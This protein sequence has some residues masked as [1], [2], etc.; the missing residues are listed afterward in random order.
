MSEYRFGQLGHRTDTDLEQRPRCRACR[1]ELKRPVDR[2]KTKDGWWTNCQSCR[3]KHTA[4][5]RQKIHDDL[6]KHH[7]STISI[8]RKFSDTIDMDNAQDFG[9][10]SDD[11]PAKSAVIYKFEEITEAQW[12][13][14]RK[15]L[16]CVNCDEDDGNFRITPCGHVIC[17]DCFEQAR[18]L[19]K[20]GYLKYGICGKCNAVFDDGV[21][22]N[23]KVE[24]L[25]SKKTKQRDQFHNT[26]ISPQMIDCAVCGDKFL[27]IDLADLS[28]CTHNPD[29]CKA[30]L[31]QWLEAQLE[32][33]TWEQMQCPSD[34]CGQ[35]LTHSDV[36]KYA[37][38]ELFTRY[39]EL[40]MRAFL[41]ADP[42]FRYCLAEG[43]NSGQIHDAE[44]ENNI[45]RCNACGFR[46]CTVHDVPFHTGKTCAQ[47]DERQRKK[48][49]KK[50]KRDQERAEQ[51]EMS[52]VEIKAST[53][54]CPGCEVPIHK[55][56]ACDHI[57]CTRC[58]F[59]F[60]YICRAPY[61]GQNGIFTAGNKVHTAEC[62]Y[63][64]QNLP[65][66]EDPDGPEVVIEHTDVQDGNPEDSDSDLEEVV[67]VHSYLEEAN[68]DDSDIENSDPEEA[69][70]MNSDGEGVLATADADLE[71]AR[72]DDSDSD[73]EDLE[74]ISPIFPEEA[75]TMNS[76]GE[77]VLAT[78][79]SDLEDT[80][81]DD[82][83]SDSEDLDSEIISPIFRGA[84]RQTYYGRITMLRQARQ[85][86]SQNEFT[87][88]RAGAGITFADGRPFNRFG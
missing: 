36:R 18:Y 24:D 17:D 76:D 48:Q 6:T 55:Y 59:E 31:L 32:S 27:E 84:P 56:E 10:V 63:H 40:S 43:C 4:E 5:R 14:H 87:R 12:K 1:K 53:V 16:V 73:S 15:H 13:K 67:A 79:D 86:A 50:R 23:A 44:A 30:C 62:K 80:R 71:D 37:S 26:H 19:A 45:F 74:I 8:K 9:E 33:T 46:V 64:P 20:G 85:R 2:M 28:D 51:D 69:I 42:N 3:S 22:L 35:I 58:K 81:P 21:L 83:D 65:D 49:E 57:T 25:P 82:L 61:R 88:M 75:V 60:C 70:T 66:Y 41:S 7:N 38:E 68:P 77:G 11:T 39:D 72:P 47:Y 52:V 78:A 34:G 54:K 29:V